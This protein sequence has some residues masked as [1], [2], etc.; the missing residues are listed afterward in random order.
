MKNEAGPRYII[1]VEESDDTVIFPVQL[2]VEN[3]LFMCID[4]L[5]YVACMPNMVGHV[6]LK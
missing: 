5:A 3:V 1:R 6:I 2:V 4:G